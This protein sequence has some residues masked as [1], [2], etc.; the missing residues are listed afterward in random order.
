MCDNSRIKY[1]RL[2]SFIGIPPPLKGLRD[3]RKILYYTLYEIKKT[4]NSQM[5]II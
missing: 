4:V 5:F 3:N 1:L 2:S